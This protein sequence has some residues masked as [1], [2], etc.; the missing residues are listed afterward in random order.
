MH[1]SIETRPKLQLI[2]CTESYMISSRI[3]L[4][5]QHT[6]CDARTASARSATTR[7]LD[8]ADKA[9]RDVDAD[10]TRVVRN[11]L[12][13]I[14]SYHVKKKYLLETSLQPPYMSRSQA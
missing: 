14:C 13:L 10:V 4:C 8:A 3:L 11:F 1:V 6:F 5:V 12:N 9:L 7:V 2:E